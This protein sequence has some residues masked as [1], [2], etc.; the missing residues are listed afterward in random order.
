MGGAMQGDEV[1]VELA[2]PRFG[3]RFGQA[4]PGGPDQRRSGRVVRVLTRRNATVVGIF[5][6]ARSGSER[7]GNFVVPFD[8]R[9]TQPVVIPFGAEVAPTSESLT[10]HR[11]LGVEARAARHYVDLEGLVV[12]VETVSYTHLDVYKRQAVCSVNGGGRLGFEHQRARS[13]NEKGEG[14]EAAASSLHAEFPIG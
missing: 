13:E 10:P 1:L 6:Y 8:E 3:S 7:G 5:H 12:D 14:G 11:V 9:M 2:A 4:R